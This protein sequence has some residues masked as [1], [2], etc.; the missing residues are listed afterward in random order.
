[1]AA[2]AAHRWLLG[3]N[4]L[5]REGHALIS[6]KEIVGLC[7][8]LAQADVDPS[9]WT[10]SLPVRVALPIAADGTNITGHLR[11]ADLPGVSVT[12]H[13]R[14]MYNAAT[15]TNRHYHVAPP[16]VTAAHTRRTTTDQQL[17]TRA[18]ELGFASLRAYLTDRAITRQWP[19]TSIAGELGVQPA[20]VRDRL[21]QHRLPP[22]PG[23]PPAL[24][25]DPAA[26]R[27]LGGQA[28]GPPGRREE[29]L[30]VR[31][32]EQG[33]SRRRTLAE[34]RVGSAWL[35]DQVSRLRVL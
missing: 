1:M 4:K 5:G 17:T 18:A 11:D 2:T 15:S 31:R 29:Y 23:D 25:G 14:R 19:T 10:L 6:S 34:L 12:Q 35:K 32:V 27:Q 20:T 28:A 26:D 13:S 9:R 7:R 30:R 22:R 24:L 33:W 8:K 21:D 3:R 16:G